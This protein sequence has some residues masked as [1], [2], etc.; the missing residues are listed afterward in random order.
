ME[1]ALFSF[2]PTKLNEQTTE[3]ALSN[4]TEKER[5]PSTSS[6][7]EIRLRPLY[8]KWHPIVDIFFGCL[9]WKKTDKSEDL[10]CLGERMFHQFGQKGTLWWKVN[11]S[12]GLLPCLAFLTCYLKQISMLS[13]TLCLFLLSNKSGDLRQLSGSLFWWTS[14]FPPK[15][16]SLSLVSSLVSLV[17]FSVQN[18][19]CYWCTNRTTNRTAYSSEIEQII[20]VNMVVNTDSIWGK[21]WLF[22][23]WFKM[24]GSYM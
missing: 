24:T 3:C 16:Y 22:N 18:L 10:K 21:N 7:L 1:F 15:R 2:S 17:E 13:Q 14:L 6:S 19:A 8:L 9:G 4:G 12:V 23:R 20:Y 5:K 11:Y